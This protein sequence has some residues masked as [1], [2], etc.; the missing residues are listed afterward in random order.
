MDRELTLKQKRFV[1][2]YIETGNATESAM[3]A[4]QLNN[5]K[6]A[7]AIGSQNLSKLYLKHTIEEKL[8]NV[9]GVIYWLALEAEKEDIR[10]RASQ[11]I[12]DRTEGKAVQRIESKNMNLNVENM[13]PEELLQIIKG[14]KNK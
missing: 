4:Y 1:D 7:K 9:K 10:L 13:T 11:D 8:T 3:Q 6:S 2:K 14:D 5:R 12:L